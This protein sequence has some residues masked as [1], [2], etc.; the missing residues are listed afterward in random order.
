MK[1]DP[2]TRA[3]LDLDRVLEEAARR[4]QTPPGAERLRGLAPTSSRV[5]VERE[6]RLAAEAMALAERGGFLSF[7]GL[8]DPRPLLEE[9]AI[10][11]YALAHEH[12]PQM[13]RL[14]LVCERLEA[15]SREAAEPHPKLAALAST[16]LPNPEVRAAIERV[17][18]RRGEDLT[19]D[20]RDDAS[21]EL[22]ELR[23]SIRRSEGQLGR[24]VNKLVGEFARRG[25]LQEAYAT[26]RGGRHVLP[27]KSNFRGR[28]PGIV[29]GSSASGE[30]IYVEPSE[31]VE[32]SNRLE[33]WRAEALAEELR[34][35]RLLTAELRPWLAA[36]EHNVA[37]VARIDSYQATARLAGEQ[38][39]AFPLCDDAQPLRLWRAHHPLLLLDRGRD[40]V[41]ITVTL[42]RGDRT[43]VLSGPNTGGKTTAMK[44]LGLT[45]AMLQC[46]LPAPCSPDSNVPLFDGLVADIGDSQ[47]LSA[48]LS[49]F[50]GHIRRLAEAFS[51]IAG[52][53]RALVLLDE[54]GT[55]TD[56]RE[57]SALAVAMLEE[58]HRTAHLSL[59][60]SHFEAVKQ[61][62]GETEGARNASFSLDSST[63]KPTY[64]VRL[65]LPGASEALEIARAEGLPAP[66]L[67]R[68]AGLVGAQHL[69]LG[70]LLRTIEERERRLAAAQQAAEGRVASL[71]EQEALARAR[72]AAL[73]EE[74]RADKI[75]LAEERE[76]LVRETRERLERLI[77]ELPSEDE[78]ERRRSVLASA[79]KDLHAEGEAAVAERK[80][81]QR[82]EVPVADAFLKPG[83]RVWVRTLGDW[84]Q[85][86]SAPPKGKV[87][88]LLGRLEVE[89]DRR[90]CFAHDPKEKA[91]EWRAAMEEAASPRAG[92]PKPRRSKR[93]KAA[94]R[95]AEAASEPPM[96]HKVLL[97]SRPIGRA[98]AVSSRPVA[99]AEFGS[100]LELDLHGKRVDEALEMVD[101]FI[102]RSLL[103]SL[104]YVRICHGTGTGRLYR[105]VHEFL[106][107]HQSVRAYRFATPD[108]GGGGVTIVDL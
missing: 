7:S 10:P 53:S 93:L 58:L 79:R 96:R 86:L 47:D 33:E 26:L 92:G 55:G 99:D 38:G 70:E 44:T 43:V 76:R 106:R 103:S 21:A 13:Y 14:L 107:G 24:L 78:Y 84:A 42:N 51:V 102:D 85:V 18:E 81:L 90:E 69:R 17:F 11:G 104:P 88:L 41:P 77:A 25:Y 75:R 54:L 105:A 57:G 52:T 60:T 4:C 80:S 87:R 16:V 61:W 39:W 108:E 20:V 12:W 71:E 45:A 35:L 73:R 65:D 49:T 28:I 37:V 5:A 89:A 36:A 1:L 63:R 95:D 91:A 19:T 72:A 48:G 46:G 66:I 15:F 50:S 74:R 30:T 31:L 56:P 32:E 2:R 97:A 8:G 34:V 67:A 6:Q 101:R 27:L 29:H 68:A 100:A 64:R 98:A 40:S 59:A 9:A 62:A 82:E 3:L 83:A 23:R 22:G 94:L